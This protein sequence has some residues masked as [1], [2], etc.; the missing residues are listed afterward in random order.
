[1]R[2]LPYIDNPTFVT[3]VEAN[4]DGIVY[5]MSASKPS[6]L[7]RVDVGLG[8]LE[9]RSFV[10][11]VRQMLDT[12]ITVTDRLETVTLRQLP[13]TLQSSRLA[14]ERRI[15]KR[16]STY[17]FTFADEYNVNTIEAS[18]SKAKVLELLTAFSRGFDIVVEMV[19][20]TIAMELKRD[21]TLREIRPLTC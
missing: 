16:G 4:G 8:V 15:T 3:V 20:Q 14:F 18:L 7:N 12:V 10:R 5:V 6:G 19:P 17:W 9:G 2:R 11:C 1:M 13:Q 21:R